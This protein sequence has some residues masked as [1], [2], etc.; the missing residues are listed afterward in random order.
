MDLG[1]PSSL[2]RLTLPFSSAVVILTPPGAI[3]PLKPR[4]RRIAN[5]ASKAVHRHLEG[6]PVHEGGALRRFAS[7]Y[8][9]EVVQ[10]HVDQLA[11][12]V[13]LGQPSLPRCGFQ[14]LPLLRVKTNRKRVRRSILVCEFGSWHGRDVFKFNTFV[15]EIVVLFLDTF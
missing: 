15:K 9:L 5:F 11:D 14:L 10:V 13:L 7:E 3:A 4:E 6:Q 1:W 2:N 12:E 8:L